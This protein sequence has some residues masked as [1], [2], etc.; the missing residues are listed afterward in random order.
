VHGDGHAQAGIQLEFNEICPAGFEPATSV[1]VQRE[2]EKP[3]LGD[4]DWT[5]IG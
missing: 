4:K 3:G 5:V 2:M 1:M